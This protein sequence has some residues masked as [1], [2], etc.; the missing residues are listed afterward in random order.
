MQAKSENYMHIPPKCQVIKHCYVDT[1]AECVVSA[2]EIANGI[3]TART[4]AKPIKNY[5]PVQILNTT[6]REITLK[7][8]SPQID[9]LSNFEICSFSKVDKYS[10]ERIDRLLGD[11]N[12]NHL[13][14]AEKFSIQRICTKYADIFHVEGDKLGTSNV[15]KQNIHL[16]KHSQPAYKKPYRLPHAQKEEV[17]RQVEKMLDEGII[18]KSRSEWSAPLLIIPKKADLNGHKQWRM[19]IDYRLLNREIEDDKF[20]LPNI[21]E[22][23]DS[24]SGAVYFSHLDLAQG[25][26]QIELEPSSRPYTAFTTDK[27]QYQMTRLPMG[28]KISPSAFSRAMTI[29]MSGLNYDTC[30]IYLD[31]LIVYG[32]SLQDHNK[33]LV[34]VFERLRTVNLKLNPNKCD[35]LKQEIL[36]LGHVISSN[37]VLPDNSKIEALQN[38]PTPKNGEEVKRFV[39]FANYYRKFIQNFAHIA[40]PLNQLTRKNVSFHWSAECQQAFETLKRALTNPP[41]LNYPKFSANNTFTLKTD[42]SG[43]AIGAVL[44]NGDDKPIA[45]ASRSLNKA[46]RNYPTIEKELLAITWAVKHFRVYLLSRHFI[47]YTDHKPLIYLFGMTNPSSRLTKFRLIL[48]EYDYTVQYIKGKDNVAADALSRISSSELNDLHKNIEASNAYV[49][50]RAKAT[51][52]NDT[53]QNNSD[54]RSRIDHPQVVEL[55]KHPSDAHELKIVSCLEFNKLAKSRKFETYVRENKAFYKEA[56]YDKISHTIYIAQV[57]LSTL[58]LDATMKALVLICKKYNIKELIISKDI[59]HASTQKQFFDNVSLLKKKGIK[60]SVI[61]ANQRIYN[62]DKKQIILNDFH[63][64]PTGGHAGINRMYNNVKKYYFWPGLHRDV[65][66][67]IRNCE[68][69]QKCKYSI[70]NNEPMSITTTATAAFEKVFVDLVGPLDPDELDNKYILTVQCDLSKFI[71]C[72]PLRNKEATTVSQALVNNFILRYGVP[73]ELVSDQGTEFLASTFKEICKLLHIN[74]LN[75]TAYHHQT[76]G[77]LENSH[78]NLG[79]YLRIQTAKYAN[80]WSTWLPYWSFSYNTTVHTETRYTPYELVFGKHAKLPSNLINQIEPLYTFDNYP[81]ELKYRLQQACN[82]ARKN[83]LASKEKRKLEYDK[84]SNPEYYIIGEKVLLRNETGK[85]SEILYKGPYKIVKIDSPNISI[86][87]NGKIVVVHKNRVKKYYNKK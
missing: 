86:R 46:E 31:D 78:K 60:I 22:I 14:V 57:T 42:A 18:E 2:N 13:S 73:S 76:L 19:V 63:M 53:S 71:E 58:A 62:D 64:L 32:N 50:T 27:G 34:K 15:Y 41:I 66:K 39:A 82:D 70:A 79:A 45:Y 83:L 87:I 55:L 3:Y 51:K 30:L 37:G 40:A 52:L 47:V 77:A 12:I 8:F 56:L 23:I 81:N 65:Q 9:L 48:E 1:H 17:Q 33:N 69:C 43:Y 25:Y 59:K 44:S 75:S 21:T 4:I 84:K 16:K 38:Y 35:F 74:Q 80:S 54:S 67:F 26:H 5:I 20:P 28:L 72:Y 36:Y 24:L 10:V 29:A 61:K 6:E 85:K 49:I 68:Q 7:N 11:I